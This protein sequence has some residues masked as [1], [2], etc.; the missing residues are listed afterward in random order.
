M[1]RR[2]KLSD[3]REKINENLE[4]AHDKSAKVYNTRTR[5]IEYKVG[6]EIFRK[7]HSLSNFQ[8]AINAK[9]S[10]KYIKCRVRNKIGNSLYD[11]EDLQGRL[12][13]RFHASDLKQ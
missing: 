8:K 6:Q 4:K 2:D 9:F 11:V 10:P 13:G 12:V 1:K 3:I 7:N 5:H